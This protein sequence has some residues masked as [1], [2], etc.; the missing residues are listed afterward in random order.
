MGQ[1]LPYFALPEPLPKG[2]VLTL[3]GRAVPLK[4]KELGRPTGGKMRPELVLTEALSEVTSHDGPKDATEVDGPGIPPKSGAMYEQPDWQKKLYPPEAIVCNNVQVLKEKAADYNAQ[5][6]IEKILKVYAKYLKSDSIDFSAKCFRRISMTTPQD[7][8]QNL[9]DQGKKTF[10]EEYAKPVLELL[11]KHGELALIVS[12]LTCS[13]MKTQTAATREKS[14]GGGGGVPEGVAPVGLTGEAKMSLTTT[15]KLQGTYEGEVVIACSYLKLV[16]RTEE[17][18]KKGFVKRAVNTIAGWFR[19]GAPSEHDL[20]VPKA[21]V[22]FVWPEAVWEADGDTIAPSNDTPQA[23][24]SV[25]LSPT[26]LGGNVGRLFG[27]GN[28][29]SQ[30]DVSQTT[31][32]ELNFVI[33]SD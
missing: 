26:P 14:G 6:V 13:D 29:Q 7:Q 3:L 5:L 17:P 18:K 24:G 31:S 19:G 25:Y 9:L 10:C 32:E 12:I 27:A 28:G 2:F 15:E 21:K 20:I 23:Q 11:E 8:M 16:W 1:T 30:N 22:P 33:L 4:K